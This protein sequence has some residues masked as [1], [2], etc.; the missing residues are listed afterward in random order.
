MG[1][2]DLYSQCLNKPNSEV[3]PLHCSPLEIVMIENLI[4]NSNHTSSAIELVWLSKGSG[5]SCNDRDKPV[6]D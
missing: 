6:A 2:V 4:N 1:S 5:A 3:Q